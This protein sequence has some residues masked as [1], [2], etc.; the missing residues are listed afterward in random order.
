MASLVAVAVGQCENAATVYKAET[1]VKIW[2]W[3][4]G[5]DNVYN[6]SE[7]RSGKP[8]EEKQ[9]GRGKAHTRFLEGDSP[10]P[11]SR[12][13]AGISD[14]KNGEGV[15]LFGGR[16]SVQGS[17][18]LKSDIWI[19]HKD[20][21]KWSFLAQST[22]RPEPRRNACVWSDSD[23]MYLF[24]GLGTNFV[25]YSD[26][27]YYNLTSKL[28]DVIIRNEDQ[29]SVRPSIRHSSAHWR[30]GSKLFLFGGE[31]TGEAAVAW[32]SDLWVA[33]VHERQ[34]R[35]LSGP[36]VENSP[37]FYGS[38]ASMWPGARAGAA[39]WTLDDGGTLVLFG[40]EGFSTKATDRGKLADTWRYSVASGR[41]TTLDPAGVPVNYRNYSGTGYFAPEARNYPTFWY[42]YNENQAYFYGGEAA[43]RSAT[44]PPALLNDVWV[45]DDRLNRW[46][47]RTVGNALQ[48]RLFENRAGCYGALGE[49]G[50]NVTLP[51]RTG[52]MAFVLGETTFIYGGIGG[53]TAFSHYGINEDVWSD[54]V[55]FVG[56]VN[57]AA[58]VVPILLVLLLIILLLLFLFC[59][60]RRRDRGQVIFDL[61][62][63]FKENQLFASN[64]NASVYDFADLLGGEGHEAEAEDRKQQ[65]LRKGLDFE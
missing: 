23:G 49:A 8:F 34:W 39:Q 30:A 32:F 52:G 56:S 57:V 27:W 65:D 47:I 10:S 37:G 2:R 26:F 14:W 48:S 36:R 64:T 13:F 40:G 35:L 18:S 62:G 29:S 6:T 58:I 15:L 45:L 59:R 44:E 51:S 20:S 63:Q 1:A 5:S 33:D 7:V 41:W 46:T 16:V 22:R 54:K 60:R 17:L 55:L 28:W 3:N 31:G 11:G 25:K 61:G 53:N 21:Q 12:A 38:A 4:S 9:R 50:I 43:E 24:G 19:F 42:D